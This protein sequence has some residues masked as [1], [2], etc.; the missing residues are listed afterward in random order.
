MHQVLR[1]RAGSNQMLDAFA[2]AELVAGPALELRPEPGTGRAIGIK[3]SWVSS[4]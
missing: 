4:T 3:G 2:Q 1:R